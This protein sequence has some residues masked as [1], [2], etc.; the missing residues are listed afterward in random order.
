MVSCCCILHSC[1]TCKKL[2]PWWNCEL[3]TQYYNRQVQW[4]NVQ[5]NHCGRCKA[6]YCICYA[7]WCANVMQLYGTLWDFITDM[8]ERNNCIIIATV[9]GLSAFQ[10]VTFVV[11]HMSYCFDFPFLSTI[12][13]NENTKYEE[14][15]WKK[16]KIYLNFYITF[17][18]SL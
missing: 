2:L 10:R 18:Y 1:T 12:W 8:I 17:G 7:R 15:R 5:H 3:I 16:K 11:I 14:H 13:Q 9:I 6:M 4:G